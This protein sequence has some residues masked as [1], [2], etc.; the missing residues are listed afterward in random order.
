MEVQIH[1]AQLADK[2]VQALGGIVA[3]NVNLLPR[4]Y[5]V[6]GL[7]YLLQSLHTSASYAYAVATHG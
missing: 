4:H 1:A 7:H 5:A 2:L 3:V 6:R